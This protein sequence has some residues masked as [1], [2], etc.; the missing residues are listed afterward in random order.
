MSIPSARAGK[1]IYR[2]P[3]FNRKPALIGGTL[4]VLFLLGLF[5]AGEKR[6][7]QGV[8]KIVSTEVF[9]ISAK[10]ETTIDFL[11]DKPDGLVGVNR[12]DIG[13]K[14]MG[15]DA[16]K[17]VEDKLAELLESQRINEFRMTSERRAK[18]EDAQI[19]AYEDAVRSDTKVSGFGANNPV[20]EAHQKKLDRQNE[21]ATAL[22]PDVL[23]PA[24]AVATP[25]AH[26]NAGIDAEKISAFLATPG[27]QDLLARFGINSPAATREAT[28]NT[29]VTQS[30]QFIGQRRQHNRFILEEEV[31]PPRSPYEL[32]TGTLISGAMI[33]ATN[34]DLPGDIVAQVTK[35]IYDTASGKYLLVPQGSKLFG[36]YDAFVAL[37]QE[38]LVIVWDRLIFPDAETLDIGGMQ[39]YDN[40]GLSGFTDKVNTHFLRTLGNAFLIS[41][42]N[43]AGEE[44]VAQASNRTDSN[45]TINLAQDFADTTSAAFSEYLRNRLRIK[46]TLEIRAGY[47]FNI[48]VSKDMDFPRPYER[49]FKA[50]N[51]RR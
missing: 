14:P 44:L 36:R 33:S 47:R 13:D 18:Y 25:P 4:V 28:D 50:Y 12:H 43:A 37:G 42:V 46:P 49:G 15:T 6:N 41:V 21:L 19:K 40:R 11:A 51:T 23:I 30:N 9:D 32:K 38:R 45:I 3:R 5:Y 7:N 17:S 1:G 2:G 26:P 27:A 16:G 8:E 10:P 48:V 24:N 34:S 35:N 29:G 22:Y 39:G 31:T 20:F